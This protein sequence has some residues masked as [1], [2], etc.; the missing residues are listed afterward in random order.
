MTRRGSGVQIPH[1]PPVFSVVLVFG[2]HSGSQ[3]SKRI[4][5][6]QYPTGGTPHTVG[7]VTD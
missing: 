7:V 4:Y 2:S 3:T 5:T 1:G 6:W